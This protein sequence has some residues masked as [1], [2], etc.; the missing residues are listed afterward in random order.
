MI[1]VHLKVTFQSSP[2]H[3]QV[4][5]NQFTSSRLG[6]SSRARAPR[7]SVRAA[8]EWAITTA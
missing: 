1:G 2:F 6:K 7:D 8:A 3:A 4:C 5:F